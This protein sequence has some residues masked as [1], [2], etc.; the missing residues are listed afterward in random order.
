MGSIILCYSGKQRNRRYHT[1]PALCTPIP[2][3]RSTMHFQRV[4]TPLPG[5]RRCGLS[6]TYRRKK[7]DRA[8]DTGNTHKRL[9]KIARV[10]RRYPRGQTDGQTHR[11]T[12]RQ[13]YSSQYFATAPA[14]EVNIKFHDGCIGKMPYFTDRRLCVYFVQNA[15]VPSVSPLAMC[16]NSTNNERREQQSFTVKGQEIRPVM[17][18]CHDGPCC[19]FHVDACVTEPNI[20]GPSR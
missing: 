4:R 9:V 19:L 20:D 12:H 8:T 16:I 14:G 11:Q 17:S 3:S 10:V 13:T 15:P 2:I 18:A 6:S 1:S 5:D 7:K